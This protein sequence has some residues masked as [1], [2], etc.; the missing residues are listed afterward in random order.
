[1]CR[2]L[3]LEGRDEFCEALHLALVFVDVLDG[4]DASRDFAIMIEDGGGAEADPC[5]GSIVV[6]AE[7]L[8]WAN[9]SSVHNGIGER[10]F[11]RLDFATSGSVRDRVSTVIVDHSGGSDG[12]AKDVLGA[13]VAHDDPSVRSVGYDDADWDGVEDCL[14]TDRKSVV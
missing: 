1:M 7:I 11:L 3:V 13:R 2:Q 4:D 9:G 6:I 14:K 10:T 8:S 5:T 12:G